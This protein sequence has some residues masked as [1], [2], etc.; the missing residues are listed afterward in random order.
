MNT[1]KYYIDFADLSDLQREI[2][3]LKLDKK[4]NDDIMRE[5]NKKWG[6]SYTANYISTIFK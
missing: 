1:L 2:L 6:K 4:K 3:Q 5:I